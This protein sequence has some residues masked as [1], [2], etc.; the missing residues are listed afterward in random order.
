MGEL[1][2][3]ILI[4]CRK[5][6]SG[7]SECTVSVRETNAHLLTNA[8]AFWAGRVENGILFGTHK[9]HL[10]LGEC[11]KNWVSHTICICILYDFSTLMH[12]M[13][14]RFTPQEKK[15]PI[16]WYHCCCWPGN[17]RKEQDISSYIIHLVLPKY[18]TLLKMTS[19]GIM[20]FTWDPWHQWFFHHNSILM[21]IS[22]CCN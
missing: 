10:F 22:F 12:Q 6:T 2:G 20:L 17:G 7:Y 4:I 5:N 13:L 16:S 8:S 3:I 9:G 15:I 1:W 21:E 18:S 14:L 19:L 11:S